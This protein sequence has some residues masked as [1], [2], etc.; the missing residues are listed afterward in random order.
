M[1][2]GVRDLGI[3]WSKGARFFAARVMVLRE[4]GEDL[5]GMAEEALLDTA[6][7]WLL[8]YLKGL[9][10]A[11]DW[12]AFDMLDALR[13]RLT[14]EQMTALDAKAPPSFTT[15]LGRKIAIDYAGDTPEIQL[16]LQEMF[17]QTT[18]PWPEDPTV[19]DPTLR[20]KRPKTV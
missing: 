7:D 1:L 2:D 12:K 19:A 4:A 17:G 3:N 20:V 10:T 6:E 5:P 9:K 15:P 11:A 13:A 16:R 18:H 8:P 14:W